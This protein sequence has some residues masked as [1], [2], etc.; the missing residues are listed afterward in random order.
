MSRRS[1]TRKARAADSP[2]LIVTVHGI[3]TFGQWQERFEQ[4]FASDPNVTVLSYKFGFFSIASFIVPLFRWWVVRCF[5]Q[6]LEREVGRRPWARVDIVAHSFGTLVAAKALRSL[7][8]RRPSFAIDTFI[9]AG[10]VLPKSYGRS[11]PP[12]AR[13]V[14][15]C[16]T[17]DAIVALGW[18]F[19][20]G[21]GNGGFA[22]FEGMTG[23]RFRNRFFR[24]GHSG[25]FLDAAGGP[26]DAFMK[27]HWLPL[28][29][30]SRPI[31]VHDEREHSSGLR[32]FVLIAL[33]ALSPL[34]YLF[35]L[36]LMALPVYLHLEGDRE[37]LFRLSADTRGSDPTE[38]FLY[39]ARA[40]R[41]WATPAALKELLAAQ[42]ASPFYVVASRGSVP[43]TLVRSLG[44]GA[45]V[46][47]RG[48]REAEI[49]EPD[50]SRRKIAG[51]ARGWIDDV[52]G[53]L[54][55]TALMAGREDGYVRTWGLDGQVGQ[56][57]LVFGATTTTLSRDCRL[58]AVGKASGEVALLALDGSSSRALAGRGAAVRAI[59]F[60]ADGNRLAMISEDGSV[61]VWGIDGTAI[62]RLPAEKGRPLRLDEDLGGQ[63]LVATDRS[64]EDSYFWQR[65]LPFDYLSSL[66]DHVTP[67]D[68]VFL[69]GAAS[70]ALAAADGSVRIWDLNSNR[71]ERTSPQGDWVCAVAALPGGGFLTGSLDGTARVFDEANGERAR[72]VGHHGF[73]RSVDVA[74]DGTRLVTGSYDGTVRVWTLDQDRDPRTS[75]RVQLAA[76]TVFSADT[77]TV[78]T[79]R[80]GQSHP[81][82]MP[83]IAP[84]YWHDQQVWEVTLGGFERLLLSRQKFGFI[85]L[86]AS[87]GD[88][89]VAVIQRF[90]NE[91]EVVDLARGTDPVALPHRWMPLSAAFAPD[92]KTMATGAAD[93]T[94]RVWSLP[95]GKLLH[96]WPAHAGMILSVS[97]SAD[98]KRL[99]S[100][101]DDKVARIWSVRGD[102]G[103]KLAGHTDAVTA[104]A[105]SRDGRLV[106]TGSKDRT[107]RL[108]DAEGHQL[109]LLRHAGEVIRVGLSSD[110]RLALTVST[111][112]SARLWDRSG[113]ELLQI[114][115]MGSHVLAA[116]FSPDGRHLTV[117][118]SDGTVERR[119]IDGQELLKIAASLESLRRS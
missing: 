85:D 106:L 7:A 94:I 62:G 10:S 100:A 114:Y 56:S 41:Q 40:Y 48:G 52:A 87:A 66:E 81:I 84:M 24:F 118:F 53:A 115:R 68:A 82:Y 95:E 65:G 113:I 91:V 16:G 29:R 47:V 72:L 96:S 57:I 117:A 17:R 74:G 102:P 12:L 97:F 22:G 30:D 45:I 25:F 13:L 109:Q 103:A 76:P 93:Q 80:V 71:Q 51:P 37:R 32:R 98:G 101:S 77:R 83:G 79:T 107:A 38:S 50:G 43:V 90:L 8:K 18:L 28:L 15:E 35:Y 44:S 39:A 63:H 112:G 58:L 59:R 99:V 11:A 4:L 110:G 2:H 86:A 108:W 105:L 116:T 67:L 36:G 73:V 75:R 64:G 111:D 26:S 6:M 34:K 89:F 88:R 49:I 5:R 70:V 104:A 20:L 33:S 19:I 21:I 119:I 61:E 3:R 54:D 55:T 46:A 14:N 92:E 23:D 1:G 78:Y 9:C 42:S 31:P 27:R 69:D 60:S